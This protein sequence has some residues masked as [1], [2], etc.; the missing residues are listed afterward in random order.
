MRRGAD[1]LPSPGGSSKGVQM[2]GQDDASSGG[3]QGVDSRHQM[4]GQTVD[5]GV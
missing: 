1:R 4:H 3:C 5:E 2:C